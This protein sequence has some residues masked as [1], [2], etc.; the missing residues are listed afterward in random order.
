[1]RYAFVTNVFEWSSIGGPQS[2][3]RNI[4]MMLKRHAEFNYIVVKSQFQRFFRKNKP[5]IVHIQ[6]NNKLIDL[7]MQHKLNLIV[8]PNVDWSSVSYKLLSYPHIHSVLIQRPDPLP[9]K[10]NPTW[11]H[12]IRKFPAFVD[13][14]FF[15]PSKVKKT[16]DVLTIGK[17]FHYDN[18]DSNL[19]KLFKILKKMNVKHLHLKRYSLKEYRNA[20]NQSKILLFP[21][22]KEAGAS[23]CHA[24]LECSMMNIP[25]IG[26]D[27]VVILRNFEY[28]SCRGLGVKTINQMAESVPTMLQKWNSYKPREWVL[29]N[30]STDAA[31]KRLKTI[32]DGD[33]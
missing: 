17:S 28:D 6:S 29:K 9:R 11:K 21:S 1:M 5:D 13:Q 12:R 10:L 33:L 3:A 15:K 24:L 31:Y 7:A 18:Y 25:F 8:G 26:L 22:P 4:E 23:L 2:R 19:N 20:L 27:G 30:F 14:E 16:I 32:V